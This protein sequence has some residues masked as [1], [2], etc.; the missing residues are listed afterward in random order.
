GTNA[1]LLTPAE[2]RALA[3]TALPASLN[4]P[5]PAPSVLTPPPHDTGTSA[6]R[7]TPPNVMPFHFGPHS[8]DQHWQAAHRRG[9]TCSL[10][11][12]SKLRFDIDTPDDFSSLVIRSSEPT[13]EASTARRELQSG[14]LLALRTT[15]TQ[16]AEIGRAH[17]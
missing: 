3:T 9:I 13:G 6:W 16:E 7:S 14:S 5:R 15:H 11:H 17:V 1:D 2:R 4:P 8:S 10:I 12:L